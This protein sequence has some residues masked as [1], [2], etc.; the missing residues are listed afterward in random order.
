MARLVERAGEAAA[1][2]SEE[3]GDES[4]GSRPSRLSVGSA[5]PPPSSFARS[6]QRTRHVRNEAALSLI[7]TVLRDELFLCDPRICSHSAVRRALGSH[8]AAAGRGPNVALHE[9]AQEQ[10]RSCVTDDD[11]ASARSRHLKLGDVRSGTTTLPTSSAPA[12]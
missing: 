6:Q 5:S 11:D 9:W 8:D 7:H 3:R 1:K 10:L 4:A 2:E 12:P